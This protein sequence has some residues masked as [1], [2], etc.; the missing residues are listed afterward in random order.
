MIQILRLKD[1]SDI[2]CDTNITDTET[3]N[4][5]YP[6]MFDMTNQR[7]VLQH[8]LPLAAMKGTSVSIRITEIVC[9]MEPTDDFAQYYE[10]A[11]NKLN[12]VGEPNEDE[13]YNDIME[14]LNELES[15]KGISIH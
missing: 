2:I 6:M 14:A 9:I 10:T 7:L 15:S 11:V 12:S 4:L 5:H 1:G 3:V 8:W 13:D